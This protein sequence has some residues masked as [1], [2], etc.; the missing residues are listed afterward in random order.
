MSLRSLLPLLMCLVLL[1]ADEQSMYDF[2]VT[3][4]D[5]KEVDMHRYRYCAICKRLRASFVSGKEPGTDAQIKEHVQSAYNVTFDLFHKVDV[6]G[7]DAIPLYNYLTS[8]K[9][10]PFFIRRIEW[11]FV[12]FLV[13]RSGIPYDR[14]APTTSPNDMLADILALLGQ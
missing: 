13:D 7:D 10:S 9:R 4:I 14:Y 2:S 8:K 3:D 12:K 1:R 5:G 6:N 11:N